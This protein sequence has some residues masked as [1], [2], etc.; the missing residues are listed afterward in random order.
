[1]KKLLDTQ[2]LFYEFFD[3]KKKRLLGRFEGSWAREQNK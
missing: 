3:K 2:K 1:L